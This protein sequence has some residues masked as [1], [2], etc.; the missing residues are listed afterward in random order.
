MVFGGV[1]ADVERSH[2]EIA[3]Q[4]SRS[5]LPHEQATTTATAAA[6]VDD[7]VTGK[8]RAFSIWGPIWAEAS[9]IGACVLRRIT[10]RRRGNVS[11]VD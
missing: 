9:E 6:R 8:V 1:W 7:K 2:S 10:E 11:C 3:V 4:L 5:S